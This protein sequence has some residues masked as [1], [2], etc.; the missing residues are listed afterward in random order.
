MFKRSC[1]FSPGGLNPAWGDY[2]R[3]MHVLCLYG[4]GRGGLVPPGRANQGESEVF[5]TL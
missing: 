5:R 4:L 3:Y 2:T 1:H